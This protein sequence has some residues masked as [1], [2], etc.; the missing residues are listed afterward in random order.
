VTNSSG[1]PAFSEPEVYFSSLTFLG[2]CPA[3][4][5]NP[6]PSDP[7]SVA[8]APWGAGAN[9]SSHDVPVKA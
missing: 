9:S 7:P 5:A 2:T 8:L 3:R 4:T 6:P 1:R